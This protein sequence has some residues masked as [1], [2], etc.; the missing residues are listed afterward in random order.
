[1]EDQRTR[2]GENRRGPPFLRLPWWFWLGYAG[3]K[4]WFLTIPAGAVLLL[5]AWLGADWP[6]GLRWAALGVGCLLLLSF[7]AAAALFVFQTIDATAYRRLLDRDETL[8]GLHLPAGSRVH[9]AHKDHADV[10]A[11]D[12][13]G[14]TEIKGMRLT[15]TLRR[16]APNWNCVLAEDQILDGFP[17]RRGIAVFD[18]GGVIQKFTLAA[19]HALLG[20]Q[21]PPLTMVERG[22][23]TRPWILILPPDAGVQVPAFATTAPP[24]VTLYVA[25]DGQLVGIGSGHG[26]EIVIRGIP[27][28]SREMQLRGERVVARLAWAFSLAG[29]MR[30]AGTEV[31]VDL[32]TGEV[33]V[34][35]K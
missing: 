33:S 32:P 16:F 11:I 26:Q 12:L 18:A 22:N 28:D 21:L 4:V 34:S 30:P 35:G 7:P 31:E 2:R 24:G 1:M 13:P 9:F 17:C 19:A 27:L 3:V 20:L 14:V 25:A 8:E 6:G 10:V 5:V 15:G 23:D 29:A